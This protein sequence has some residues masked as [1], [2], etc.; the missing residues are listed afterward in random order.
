M[1][2]RLRHESH[3]RHTSVIAAGPELCL[4]LTRCCQ[5]IIDALDDDN[6]DDED[7]DDDAGG[8]GGG[9][10]SSEHAGE[11]SPTTTTRRPSRDK[12]PSS[13]PTAAT[14][15][16]QQRLLATLQRDGACGADL[17]A[18]MRFAMATPAQAE[19]VYATGVLSPLVDALHAVTEPAFLQH[20]AASR[21]R[22]AATDA[23]TGTGV[24]AGIGSDNNA[25]AVDDIGIGVAL[26]DTIDR[27]TLFIAHVFSFPSPYVVQCNVMPCHVFC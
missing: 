10:G 17:L 13:P 8:G 7:D 9:G 5:F 1:H 27:V 23:N 2:A 16:R 15:A 3:F 21:R 11:R 18:A 22:A 26:A 4:F 19:S 20:T 12:L 14:F 24:C 6:D 25:T